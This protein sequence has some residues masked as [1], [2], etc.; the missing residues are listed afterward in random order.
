MIKIFCATNDDSKLIGVNMFE[1]NMME[2]NF[3]EWFNVSELEQHARTF[4]DN[5]F[6]DL[7]DISEVRLCL[8]IHLYCNTY[9]VQI[10]IHVS[11]N[12]WFYI[13]RVT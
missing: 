8:Y 6:D 4:I 5:G 1:T 11:F 12:L 10:S 2:T 9:V 3:E 7:Q 13:L